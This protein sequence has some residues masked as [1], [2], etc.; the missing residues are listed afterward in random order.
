MVNPANIEETSYKSLRRSLDSMQ[1]LLE[2]RKISVEA[3]RT[4]ER[5]S[6]RR[7]ELFNSCFRSV[8]R[9]TSDTYKELTSTPAFPNGGTAYLSLESPDSPF[10]KGIKYS[11]MPPSKRFRDMDQLSG[12]ERTM[13]AL[14]LLFAINEYS[15]TPFLIMDEA[16]AA[17]DNRNVQ[18]MSSFL[19]SRSTDTQLIVISLKDAFFKRADVLVGI[20]RDRS[21]TSQSV[22]LNLSSRFPASEEARLSES[23]TGLL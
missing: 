18:S 13:A 20:Y 5:V 14:A 15:P 17:L 8:A 9:K 23:K 4:F 19:R 16:D 6:R 3:T 1:E 22:C 2:A 10:L 21:F 11:A 12:G 7:E